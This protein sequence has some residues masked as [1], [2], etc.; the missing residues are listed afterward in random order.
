MNLSNTLTATLDGLEEPIEVT[1]DG[2]DVTRWELAFDR[3]LLSADLRYHDIVWLAWHAAKR[4]GL[5]PLSW[6][7]WQDRC[8]VVTSSRVAPRPTQPALSDGSA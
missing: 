6:A 1:Y 3:S 2:R 4:Q 7:E 8:Q 5:T